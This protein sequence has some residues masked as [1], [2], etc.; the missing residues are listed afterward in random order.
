MALPS[1]DLVHGLHRITSRKIASDGLMT[2]ALRV[3]YSAATPAC[4]PQ[5]K[6]TLHRLHRSKNLGHRNLE[7]SPLLLPS[8][9]VLFPQP[10][11][12]TRQV[13][14][15]NDLSGAPQTGQGATLRPDS[16]KLEG[17]K[18]REDGCPPSRCLLKIGRASVAAND[19]Q[20]NKQQKQR[21]Q[22]RQE[23]THS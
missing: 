3:S 12:H 17:S 13:F 11:P 23:Q 14:S 1:Q 5:L 22:Q 21:Q 10:R 4:T 18:L 8:C 2:Q 19:K 20:D 7:V 15:P 9:P 16:P 6:N